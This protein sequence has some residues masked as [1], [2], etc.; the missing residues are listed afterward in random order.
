MFLENPGPFDTLFLMREIFKC[1]V[2]FSDHSLGI[3]ASI[4]AINNGATIIE[5]HFTLDRGLSGPDHK[6]SLQPNELG[7][8][9]SEIRNIELALGDGL[10]QPQKSEHET[11]AIVRKSLM[12]L[13]SIEKDTFFTGL[14]KESIEIKP[15]GLSSAL[16]F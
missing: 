9:I 13:N 3:G 1:E 4:T 5:K 2:G 7:A 10:K 8:L 15:S 14:N 16:F 12:A 11:I 6:A